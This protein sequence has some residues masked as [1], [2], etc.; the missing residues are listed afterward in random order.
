MLCRGRSKC[1]AMPLATSPLLACFNTHNKTAWIVEPTAAIM[2]N[3]KNKANRDKQL[4]AVV[5][6]PMAVVETASTQATVVVADTIKA[7]A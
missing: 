2:A 7:A 5:A 4:A 3:N 1:S 6:L